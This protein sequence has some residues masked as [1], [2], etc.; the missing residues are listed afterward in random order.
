M[1]LGK[2]IGCLFFSRSTLP[3][4]LDFQHF[5][6]PSIDEL[7]SRW[8]FQK[9]VCANL[10]FGQFV[11]SV[12]GQFVK[13]AKNF[14][15]RAPGKKMTFL[16]PHWQEDHPWEGV[17]TIP[18]LT[19]GT[20]HFQKTSHPLPG[21]LTTAKHGSKKAMDFGQNSPKI[22]CDFGAGWPLAVIPGLPTPGVGAKKKS[23]REGGV[24]HTWSN[25]MVR[26]LL[27]YP[28]GVGFHFQKLAV[29]H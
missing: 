9:K 18:L 12:F 7:G 14:R 15:C 23:P 2:V 16:D 26:T 21:G 24:G 27:P 13:S 6:T 17:Q 10:P 3:S 5:N 8:S 25:G 11:K 4:G 29:S 1:F 19:R 20:F 22:F 28:G